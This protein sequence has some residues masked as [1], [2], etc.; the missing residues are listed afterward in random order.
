MTLTMATCVSSARTGGNDR[1]YRIAPRSSS[2]TRVL[3]RP[4]S[5]GLI[6]IISSDAITAR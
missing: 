3:R 6:R 4:R 5:D 1:M 2:V